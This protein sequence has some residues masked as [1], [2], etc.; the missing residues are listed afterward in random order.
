MWITIFRRFSHPR[1][2]T[3]ILA[4]GTFGVG[5]E[6]LTG[7]LSGVGIDVLSVVTATPVITEE[8]VG[9]VTDAVDVMADVLAVAIINV[10]FTIDAVFTIDVNMTDENANCL[11]AVMTLVEFSSS[12]P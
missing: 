12:A 9:G 5:V 4:D 6:L 1:V 2:V 11:A 7:V 10:V 3:D 8:F